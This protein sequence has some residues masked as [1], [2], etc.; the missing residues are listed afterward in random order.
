MF[1]ASL[2]RDGASGDYAPRMIYAVCCLAASTALV[3][4]ES[5]SGDSLRRAIRGH[6]TGELF[7]RLLY[8]FNFQGIADEIAGSYIE[9]HGL[10]G[11]AEIEAG[12]DEAACSKLKSYWSFS[13]CGYQKTAETC[14]RPDHLSRCPLPQNQ[15]RNGRLNQIAYALF[16]FIRDIADGDLVSWVDHQLAQGIE[17]GLYLLQEALR[18]TGRVPDTP[19]GSVKQTSCAQNIQF[20]PHA[21]RMSL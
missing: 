1:C 3:E 6:D 9:R 8:A 5:D 2:A 14:S 12:L 17:G 13:G 18:R 20:R 4:E 10:P 21:Q 15:F 7:H 11:W 19:G 16:L